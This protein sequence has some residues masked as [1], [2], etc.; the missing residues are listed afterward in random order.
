MTNQLQTF[1]NEEFGEIRTTDVDGKPYF[2]ASDIAKALG[3]ARPNDA[4]TD[5]CR[6]TVKRRTP[7]SGKLQN[8]NFIP[9]GD[10]YRLIVKSRLPSAQ[11]FEHWVFDEI[12]PTIRKTGGYV[13]SVD[14]MV[15]T[16][17]A[18]LPNDHKNLIR[19]LL[20]NIEQQQKKI[21]TLNSENDLLSQK[22]L[23]W[24]DRPLIN[25]LVRSYAGSIG[26]NFGKAWNTFKKEILY[27]H[28]IN[29]NARITNYLNT[30]GK[31]TKPKTLEMLDDSELPNAVST[32][33]AMCRENDVAIDEILNNYSQ[34][35]SA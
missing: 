4:V 33:V 5:H 17:F 27:R 19:G 13:N 8:V 23:E 21:T 9:E 15:D 22:V 28:S 20:S 12:L 1:V 18:G 6:A 32:A 24:A 3:Y 11:K 35:V 26:N 25:A 16:Y 34:K 10:V 31:H 30:S 7:I 29:L 2:C 14:L